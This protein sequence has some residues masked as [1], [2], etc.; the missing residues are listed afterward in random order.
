VA[1]EAISVGWISEAI[2]PASAGT[3]AYELLGH[4]V[5]VGNLA[6]GFVI[7]AVIG[8]LNWRGA[9][10]AAKFQDGL[11][12]LLIIASS[13][14]IV[15][16]LL[17]GDPANLSPAFPEGVSPLHALGAALA[18]TPFFYAGFNTVPQALGESVGATTLSNLGRAMTATILGA[19]V[20]YVLVILSATI[21]VPLE[22]FTT[23]DL[24]AAAAFE[25]AL[26]SPVWAKLVLFA[27]W[28]GLV[29]TWN[30]VLFAGA[31]A[32]FSLGQMGVLPAWFGQVHP[33]HGSPG[34]AV[35]FVAVVGTLLMLA[36]RGA[37]TPIVSSTAA[38]FSMMFIFTSVTFVVLR[39]RA[40]AAHRPYRAPGGSATP[41][42][43]IVVSVAMLALALRESW[44]GME[45]SALL[46][47]EW[48]V[49]GAWMALGV[50][51]RFAGGR[52]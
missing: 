11:T 9:G 48:W 47:K 22:Q 31:R 30:A 24:P 27:G 35:L 18:I 14:F 43:A 29:T 49:I 16:G 5:R 34:N 40:R 45:E 10:T 25:A 15:A 12:I 46:P 37:V 42:V 26:G 41:A 52:R 38:V 33:R 44:V 17:R 3:V 32:L 20:F 13:V 28:L 50:L 4:S 1:F 19:G 21:S 6:V 8:W 7:M 23:A 36:G 2:V 39:R 51:I